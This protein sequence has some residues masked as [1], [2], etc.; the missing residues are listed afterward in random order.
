MDITSLSPQRIVE[1]LERF[2]VIVSYAS[3]ALIGMGKQGEHWNRP[4]NIP[5]ADLNNSFFY[6]L[7]SA[8]IQIL[9]TAQ[10]ESE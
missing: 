6:G 8:I 9:P 3:K 2:Y 7:F 5:H 1:F 4:S 10:D